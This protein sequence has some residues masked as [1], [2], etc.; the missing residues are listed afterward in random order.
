MSI[1]KQK[2]KTVPLTITSKKIKHLGINLAKPVQALYAE[3]YEKL[4]K[5]SKK[6]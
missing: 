4:R 1:V 5:K 2:L 3:N 6:T